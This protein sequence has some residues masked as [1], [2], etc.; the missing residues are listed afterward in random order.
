MSTGSPAIRARS[1]QDTLA[2]LDVYRPGARA[3]VEQR[4]PAHALEVITT[5]LPGGYIGIDLDAAMGREILAY[6]GRDEAMRFWIRYV[7]HHL[8]S[9]LLAGPVRTAMSLLGATPGSLIKWMPKVLPLVYRDLFTAVVERLEPRSAKIRYDVLSDVF[10]SEPVY[11]VVIEATIRSLFVVAN[12]KCGDVRVRT[13][14]KRR[15]YEIDVT[16]E[17]S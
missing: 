4:L 14:A 3:A 6:L 17:M 8:D 15:A 2:Y 5:T 11:A 12:A 10:L 1:C 13:D 7:T 16:W 9:P